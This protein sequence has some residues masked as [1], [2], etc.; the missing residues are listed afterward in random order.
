MYLTLATFY[1]RFTDNKDIGKHND[2]PNSYCYH[3]GTGGFDGGCD[4]VHTMEPGMS[5]MV[6]LNC[7]T[8]SC[9]KWRWD[10]YCKYKA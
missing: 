3:F 8:W 4:G 6:F 10:S 9:F 7:Y 5:K 2:H 1:G